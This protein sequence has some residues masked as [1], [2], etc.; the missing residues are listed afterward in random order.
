MARIIRSIAISASTIISGK[1][2]PTRVKPE[3]LN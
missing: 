3:G 2:T 1:D